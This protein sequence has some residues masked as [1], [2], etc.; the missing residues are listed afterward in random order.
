[1]GWSVSTVKDVAFVEDCL[2]MA[3]WRRDQAGRPVLAGMI[4]HSDAESP[5]YTGIRFTDILAL[6]V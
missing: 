5:Q 4:H 2:A 6:K 1:V 3:M